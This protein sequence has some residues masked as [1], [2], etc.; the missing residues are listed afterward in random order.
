MQWKFKVKRLFNGH[1]TVIKLPKGMS[2]GFYTKRLLLSVHN[3]SNIQK[4]NLGQLSTKGLTA[5]LKKILLTARNRF[6]IYKHKKMV[7]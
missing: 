6:L 5:K 4:P 3:N 7:T 2:D 1:M